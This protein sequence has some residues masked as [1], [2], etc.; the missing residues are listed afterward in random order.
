MVRYQPDPDDV[1]ARPARPQRQPHVTPT[2]AEIL[3][4]EARGYR[5][6]DREDLVRRTFGLSLAR[7]VQLLNRAIDT[8][9]A[10]TID[11]TTTRRLQRIRDHQARLRAD[12]TPQ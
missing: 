8:P 2:V 11:P 3:D 1:P 7:Y 12:R 10:L 6:H 9:E 4:L 5:K